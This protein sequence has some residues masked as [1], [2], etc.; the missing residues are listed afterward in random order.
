MGCAQTG[1]AR[2]VRS[3]CRSS[4]AW[5]RARAKGHHP[6]AHP[7]ADAR[8]CAADL[9]K[10]ASTRATC[11]AVRRSSSAAYRRCRRSRHRNAWDILIATP[12]VSVGS[13]GSEDRKAGQG[14]VFRAR[15][16]RP[17]VDMAFF[18]DVK[19]IVKVPAGKSARPCC[20]RRPFRQRLPIWQRK[21]C[22]S[23]AYLGNA[24][25]KTGE[26]DRAAALFCRKAGKAGTS[27]GYHPS[28][29]VHQ[30][31]VFTRTKHGA[32]RVARDLN[33]A[34]IRPSPS[35]AISRR[36]SASVRSR[37]LKVQDRGSGCD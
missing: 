3:Q 2:P 28:S 10:R 4:S 1:T 13:D 17:H 11:R 18:P 21:C 35:T 32:D 9:R 33:R 19:R 27:A 24:E 12:K 31:L 8:A 5:Q 37:T 23:R 22:M 14:R 6:C 30:V 36:I 26:Q 20:S 7:H 16:G 25:R 34:G 15:R 29:N